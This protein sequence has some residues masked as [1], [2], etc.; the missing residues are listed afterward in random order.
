[1]TSSSD[2]PEDLAES[3]K[4]IQKCRMKKY[5]THE[6]KV[7]LNRAK[8]RIAYWVCR[9]ENIIA[10]REN[11]SYILGPADA[12][13]IMG[14]YEKYLMTE[15]EIKKKRQQKKQKDEHGGFWEGAQ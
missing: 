13:E 3:V 15:E 9:T 10:S 7:D 4:F 12:A 2:V 14:A 1:M 6:E 11:L 5:L 8:L